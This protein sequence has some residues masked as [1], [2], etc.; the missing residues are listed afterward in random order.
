MT[1]NDRF[2]V[3]IVL[4]LEIV[5]LSWKLTLA[6]RKTDVYRHN[7]GPIK[8]PLNALNTIVLWCMGGLKEVLNLSPMMPRDASLSDSYQTG[9]LSTSCS[10]SNKKSSQITIRIRRVDY[11]HCFPACR[12]GRLK[13]SPD[14]SP[15]TVWDC[16]GLLCT[17]YS[18]DWRDR[19]TG[20]K[21]CDY[22]Q[23]F[24]A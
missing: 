14:V 19:D 16:A 18:L 3:K 10:N 8:S 21:H 22:S 13:G 11:A 23:T 9:N 1:S 24:R 20:P 6:V 5:L 15:S 7:D 2:V 4:F 17:L 12:V